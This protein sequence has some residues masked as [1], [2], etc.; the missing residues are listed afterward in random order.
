MRLNNRFALCSS[1]DEARETLSVAR[2]AAAGVLNRSEAL[3][4][5]F[6]S[7]Q[8]GA[9][10][11]RGY[12]QLGAVGQGSQA[13]FENLLQASAGSSLRNSVMQ[14]QFTLPTSSRLGYPE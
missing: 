9:L 11:A 7:I 1:V 10:S 3:N 4:Q 8:D 14:R 13:E 2:N 5:S 12:G 6:A